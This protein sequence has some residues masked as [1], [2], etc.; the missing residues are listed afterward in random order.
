MN[1]N[2]FDNIGYQGDGNVDASSNHT[3]S[4][5]DDSSLDEQKRA[6]Y[7]MDTQFR[8]EFSYWV[9][10]IIPTWLF[11]ILFIVFLQGFRIFRLDPTETVAL[12]ASTSANVLGLAYIVLKGFF[13][14]EK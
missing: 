3:P 1:E 14:S 6:R 13:G 11:L 12:L 10:I 4:N 9:M 7:K 5:V 8:S 2:T